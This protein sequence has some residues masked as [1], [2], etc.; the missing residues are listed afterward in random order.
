MLRAPLLPINQLYEVAN[1]QTRHF[2]RRGDAPVHALDL[3]Q[4]SELSRFILILDIRIF[5]RRM[6]CA[7]PSYMVAATSSNPAMYYPHSHTHPSTHHP[8]Q[9]HNSMTTEQWAAAMVNGNHSM[10]TF[11]MPIA[12]SNPFA[13]TNAGINPLIV[14]SGQQPLQSDQMLSDN[15]MAA[16]VSYAVHNVPSTTASWPQ[17][18]APTVT[19]PTQPLQIPTTYSP[20]LNN[21]QISPA[22][23]QRNGGNQ[24][25]PQ[26]YKWMQVK[27]HISKTPG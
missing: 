27:R 9:M 6:N 17:L 3:I 13:M 12:G 10:Q 14:Q 26:Q 20:P 7:N 24:Q 4:I 21:Q 2:T 8:H 18:I 22:E 5:E 15:L 19:P 1:C 25:R 16:A 11:G 23:N